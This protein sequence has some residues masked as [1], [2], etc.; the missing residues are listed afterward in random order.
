L[1]DK[2]V[3]GKPQQE[4]H[5]INDRIRAPQI[6]VINDLGENLGS[7]D[8]F[9]ALALA[10]TAGLDL[11]LLSE[12]GAEGIPVAKI[13]DF[14]KLL[15]ERKKKKGE[16]KKHQKVIQIKEIKFRPKIGEH[17]LQTKI[18]HAIEFLEDGKR[19]KCTIAFRGR[20]NITKEERGEEFFKRIDAILAQRGFSDNLI[21]EQ[22][23]KIGQLWSRIYYLKGS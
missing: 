1:K 10:K 7:I 4:Q 21:S 18:N 22:D 14:G 16:A 11:V 17:D 3:R 23:S 6:Q 20:E 19:V 12:S 8:R 5:M 2:Q 9:Q 15:Y 13:M